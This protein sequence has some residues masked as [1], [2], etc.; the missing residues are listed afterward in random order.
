M[1]STRSSTGSPLAGGLMILAIIVILGGGIAFWSA[2]ATVPQSE[3]GFAVGGGPVDP[4]RKKV[5]GDLLQPGRHITGTWDTTWTYP[6]YKTL[7]FQN[8]DTSITTL[9]GKKVRV[10]GQ[11]GFRFVG[12]QDARKAREFATG[13]GARKYKGHYP[14]DGG[15][16][17]WTAF[18]D[19]LVDPEITAVFKDQFG[20][21]FCADFEPACR[22]IDPRKDVPQSNPERVY[23]V[24][25]K[26]LQTRVDA[27][28]GDSYL[29]DVSVR[30]KR[31]SL[32]TE[33]QTNIDRVTSEQA[34]TQA[35]KQ[36]VQ[37][38]AQDAEAIRIRGKALKANKGL[39]GLEIAKE[40]KGGDQCTL[41]VDGTGTGV[42]PAVRAGK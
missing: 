20:R 2:C 13:L 32:P 22:S 34:R 39:I 19:Q 40:C 37:T 9:D 5:K 8:F 28:L 27:K 21:V 25:S 17:G 24:L 18:L 23:S 7:R 15:G 29:R 16:E 42:A 12:E 11:V 41:I 1:N 30:V 26:A 10:E 3:V 35:A 36:A 6:A 14:G 38:A 33:V 4:A 31:I